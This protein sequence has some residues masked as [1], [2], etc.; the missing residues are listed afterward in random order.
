MC[1][2]TLHSLP[3]SQLELL[4]SQRE[5]DFPVRM[6][7][8]QSILRSVVAVIVVKAAPLAVRTSL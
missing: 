6:R 2:H 4:V 3:L 8:V 5:S 1:L 7:G